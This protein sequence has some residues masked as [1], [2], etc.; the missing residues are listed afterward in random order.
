MREAIFVIM[1]VV[2]FSLPAFAN[3]NEKPE[4]I[5]TLHQAADELKESNPQLS[6]K[7]KDFAKKKE[8]WAHKKGDTEKY[9][10]QKTKDVQKIKEAA[11]LLE[12]THKDLTRDLRD[13]VERWEKKL[14]KKHEKAG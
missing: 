11:T 3:I 14:K 5:S 7:L 13:I 9:I 1:A 10:Q 2:C 6:K 4:L 8:K 12:A